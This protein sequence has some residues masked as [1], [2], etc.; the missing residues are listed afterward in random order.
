MGYEYCAYSR[1]L[2]QYSCTLLSLVGPFVL[3]HILQHG[4]AELAA[5]R[6]VVL[7]CRVT[8]RHACCNPTRLVATQH[9]CAL[10]GGPPHFVPFRCGRC[11]R[12]RHGRAARR[13]RQARRARPTRYDTCA[14][15]E[16]CDQ[17]GAPGPRGTTP[18]R[19]AVRG[20]HRRGVRLPLSGSCGRA[21]TVACRWPF[22]CGQRQRS[23][24]CAAIALHRV[25]VCAQA[26]RERRAS[27]AR[28]ARTGCRASK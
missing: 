17:R 26:D 15:C 19:A 11:G 16:Y 28:T 8:T 6:R 22:Y 12:Q 21:L 3:Q 5:A 18:V 7:Q 14:C 24:V 25:F 10:R 23:R 1:P 4:M 20:S 13:R 2:P 27:T 9:S